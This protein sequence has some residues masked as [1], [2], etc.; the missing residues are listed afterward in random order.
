MH[1]RSAIVTVIAILIAAGA[2]VANPGGNGDADRDFTCGGSCHGD[3]ALSSPSDGSVSVSV[4]STTYAGTATAVHVTASGMSLSGNRLLGVFILSS[5]DGNG[6]HPEDHGWNIVQDPNGGSNNYVEVLVPT[7]GSVTLTWVMLAPQTPSS[8]N[9]FVE[10]HHGSNP[11]TNNWAYSG[12]TR[13]YTVDVQPV[14]ENLPGFAFDWKPETRVT[15]DASPTAIRTTN[16]TSVSVQW[17]LE[18]E[19]IP[20]DAVVSGEGD[21]WHAQI[22]AT[23]GDTRM[24]FRVTTSNGDFSITQPWLTV[25]TQPALFDGDIWDAR[26]QSLALALLVTAFLLSLQ[27]RLSPWD[28]GPAEDMTSEVEADAAPPDESDEYW[29]RL[30]PS[31]DSPGWLWDPVEE[32]WVADPEN[33]PGGA[34]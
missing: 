31:G 6:D 8:V 25:A 1:S 15:G 14:P 13:G 9:L 4:D 10:T 34:R 2:S 26:F 32:E 3:P 11:N 30:V 12:L 16:T 19:W 33:P 5:T 28:G 22:P 27:A 18:G 23:I 24:Q 7:S 21:E 17:M 29:S 20:H